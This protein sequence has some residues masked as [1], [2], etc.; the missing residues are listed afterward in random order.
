VLV[1]A[2]GDVTHYPDP[3]NEVSYLWTQFDGV[4]EGNDLVSIGG[5]SWCWEFDDEEEGS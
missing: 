3:D 5:G 2:D 1:I 4:N